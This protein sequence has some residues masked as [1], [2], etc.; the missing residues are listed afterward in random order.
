[1]S[2]P[3]PML[4]RTTSAPDA[5]GA[6]CVPCESTP[7]ESSPGG[8]P[9]PTLEHA[10]ELSYQEYEAKEPPII[11]IKR[12]R[13]KVERRTLAIVH[14]LLRADIGVVFGSFARMMV[15]LC[16]FRETSDVD[17]MVRPRM[18]RQF[19]D[20]L[21]QYGKI[22]I[23]SRGTSYSESRLKVTTVTFQYGKGTPFEED[24]N[25]D[26]TE[27][28]FDVVEVREGKTYADTVGDMNS[29]VPSYIATAPTIIQ[30]VPPKQKTSDITQ[31]SNVIHLM[32]GWKYL[33]R[34]EYKGQFLLDAPVKLRWFYFSFL[35]LAIRH[36]DRCM[37]CQEEFL[38]EDK[39]MH[40]SCGCRD[41][42]IGHV[43]CFM[44]WI[45]KRLN[46]ILAA[47]RGTGSPNRPDGKCGLCDNHFIMNETPESHGLTA[48]LRN[49]NG[50]VVKDYTIPPP[51]FKKLFKDIFKTDF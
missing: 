51:V 36:D 41:G 12:K 35:Q 32:K 22:V 9:R 37:L 6:T 15:G 18:T 8:A 23:A 19:L 40:L 20:L 7:T 29:H 14:E 38:R 39:V 50:E 1:M 11:S 34:T 43:K 45:I 21:R 2:V 13:T 46:G 42:H 49:E 4:K 27:I 31:L 26:F 44:P 48:S 24:L 5:S 28:A 33:I 10:F 47:R 25:G 30:M 17:C 16:P 3:Q